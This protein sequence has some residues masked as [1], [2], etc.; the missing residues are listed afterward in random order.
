M[1]F[2]GII[3]AVVGFSGLV[4]STFAAPF[5][6]LVFAQLTG[7]RRAF[8]SGRS[9]NDSPTSLEILVAAH[10]EETVIT[11]TLQSIEA[12]GK[13]LVESLGAEFSIRI[14][15]GLDHCTD[16]T[17]KLV[18]KFA[19]KCVFDVNCVE[20]LSDC[21]K[22]NVLKMLIGQSKADWVAL[23]DSG[24]VWKP[25]LLIYAWNDM[26]DTSVVG[27]APSY[28]PKSSGT[29]EKY[30]WRLEQFL[31]SFENKSGG[32]ISVH[33][34]T[35]L[36]R[37]APLKNALAE[38]GDLNWLNDDVVIPLTLRL[39]NPTKRMVYLSQGVENSWVSDLGIK[40]QMGVEFRRRRRM[41]VGNLQW[42]KLILVAQWRKNLLVTAIA[43]RRFFRML[44][45][46]W[47]LMIGMG[48]LLALCGIASQLVNSSEQKFNIYMICGF[49]ALGAI[50]VFTASNWI[51]RLSMAFLSGLQLPKY[52]KEFSRDRGVMW[53]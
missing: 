34:A 38:L 52:W 15:V 14:S 1:V 16:S 50:G 48:S 5:G 6:A 37:L 12:A 11:E 8:L 4:W 10:N 23:V 29:L 41:L 31:K 27:I 46:Y 30:N 25:A 9:S 20:N 13:A 21:G 43:S 32:P 35:V 45:A 26:C 18:A 44:W 22:W 24:S 42:V 33:G 49:A 17:A 36:Y 53:L 39:Q 40:S 19:E 28:C 51:R 2:I 47:I 7:K 3:L